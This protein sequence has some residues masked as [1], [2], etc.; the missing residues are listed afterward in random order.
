MNRVRTQ[1]NEHSQGLIDAVK[2][3]ILWH[4]AVICVGGLYASAAIGCHGPANRWPVQGAV[5]FDGRPLSHGAISFFPANA[6]GS[7]PTS[8]A[9]IKDG[10][11]AVPADKGLQPGS[12]RVQITSVQKTGKKKMVH[13]TEEVDEFIDIVPPRYNSASVLTVD[14]TAGGSNVFNFDLERE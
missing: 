11:Y 6:G 1:F 8:G 3:S 7:G 4:M 13:G 2:L 12:V 5:T 14:V 10:K 9:E